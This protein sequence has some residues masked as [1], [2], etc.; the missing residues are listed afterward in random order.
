MGAPPAMKTISSRQN[1]AVVA[2]RELAATPD[3][4]GARVLLDGVHLVHDAAAAGLAFELVCVAASALERGDEA[5]LLAAALAQRG[6]DVLSATDPVFAAISPVRTPSGIVA[7]AHRVPTTPSMIAA[8]PQPFVLAIDSVQDPGNVGALLRVAEAAGVNG[9]FVSGASAHP[10]SWKALRGGM[11]SSLR[12][13]VVTGLPIDTIQASLRNDQ[14][15]SVAAVPRDGA[16]P[17]DID[18]RGRVALLVGGEGP[19]LSA[20]VIAACDER[21]TI[22]MAPPVESLNVAVAA[23]IVLYAARRQRT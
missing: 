14:V 19:G 4:A 13:P 16:A 23:A 15:R 22:P 7:I 11:G 2:C 10:F 6:V 18:W 20:E 3:A 5:G 1:P 8:W 21:V 17:D 12:L 9:A